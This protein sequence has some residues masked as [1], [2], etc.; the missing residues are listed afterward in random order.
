METFE[1]DRREILTL[2][3]LQYEEKKTNS[4]QEIEPTKLT[5]EELTRNYFKKLPNDV[6]ENLK[7]LYKYDF[8]LFNYDPQLYNK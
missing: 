5:T 8:E 7:I 1:E 3:G 2:A 4:H 6:T